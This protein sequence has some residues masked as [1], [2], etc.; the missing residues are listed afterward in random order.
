ML[1]KNDT[2][3]E[4]RIDASKAI[5]TSRILYRTNN[6]V[7]LIHLEEDCVRKKKLDF[8]YDFTYDFI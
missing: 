5:L 4:D 1:S 8:T 6:N 2:F 3:A 7:F